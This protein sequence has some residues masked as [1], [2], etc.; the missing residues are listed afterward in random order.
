M[1]ELFTKPDRFEVLTLGHVQIHHPPPQQ[2]MIT[3]TCAILGLQRIGPRRPTDDGQGC[4][5]PAVLDVVV[6][7]WANLTPPDLQTLSALWMEG[8]ELPW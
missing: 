4:W 1:L 6:D 7:Q 3:L 2:L 8:C 5:N